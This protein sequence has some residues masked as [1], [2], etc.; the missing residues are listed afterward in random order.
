MLLCLIKWLPSAALFSCSGSSVIM[1][2]LARCRQMDRQVAI[3]GIVMCICKFL[4]AIN[5]ACG[6]CTL[7]PSSYGSIIYLCEW[8]IDGWHV[9][10][11][12]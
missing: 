1:L 12:G 5:V 2:A 10:V 11:L 9:S 8:W 3:F 4:L 6:V 7:V